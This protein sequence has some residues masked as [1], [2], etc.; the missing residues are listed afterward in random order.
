MQYYKWNNHILLVLRQAVDTVWT[1]GSG[2]HSS[3]PHFRRCGAGYVTD[4]GER[5]WFPL[6]E[7]FAVVRALEEC[8][9][10]D[11]VKAQKRTKLNRP[12][13]TAES[14]WR[15]SKATRKLRWRLTWVLL[16]M[17]LTSRLPTGFKAVRHFWLLVGPKLRER[18]EARPREWLSLMSL[19]AA[20]TVAGRRAGSRVSS[21]ALT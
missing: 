19:P 2:R 3:N 7:L 9:P 13:W 18:P 1:D 15:T 6:P 4:N 11:V 8:S 21:T 20:W 12:L 16:S 10:Q 5:V 17:F 14:P